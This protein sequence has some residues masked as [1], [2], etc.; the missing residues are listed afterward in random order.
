MR[1]R[2]AA[3]RLGRADVTTEIDSYLEKTA[4]G[5]RVRK[6]VG[7]LVRQALVVAL[8]LPVATGLLTGLLALRAGALHEGPTARFAA[9]AIIAVATALPLLVGFVQLALAPMRARRTELELDLAAGTLRRADGR[10]ESLA[11]IT[12][13]AL[14]ASRS[15]WLTVSLLREGGGRLDLLRPLHPRRRARWERLARAI[16]DALDLPRA[17]GQESAAAPK[18]TGLAVLCYLPFGGIFLFVSL[19]NV[20]S[21]DPWIRFHARQS[22]LMGAVS[23]GLVVLALALVVVAVSIAPAETA[24]LPLVAFLCFVGLLQLVRVVVRIYACVNA[25][26][27]RTWLIP[28]LARW[29]RRWHPEHAERAPKVF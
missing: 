17:D 4:H 8:L 21:R 19:F 16:A 15:G 27:G 23:L 22:A 28:G 29:S 2:G 9:G 1:S 12:S 3:Q 14:V 18:N 25:H 20:R 10:V 26:R 6:P 5:L 11:G 13:V 7:D 24:S